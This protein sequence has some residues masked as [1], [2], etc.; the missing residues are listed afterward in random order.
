MQLLQTCTAMIGYCF[1]MSVQVSFILPC[2][3]VERYVADCLDSIYAQ[4]LRE[5][6]YEVI[7]VNDCSTD[8]TRSIIE[9]YARRHSNL[10]LIDHEE[11]SHGCGI[12]RNTGISKAN[13]EYICFVDADDMLPPNVMKDI[14]LTAHRDN[15]DILLFNHIVLSNGIYKENSVKYSSTMVYP[16]G[17]FVENC[18]AGN[19]GRIA[20]AWAKLFKRSFL[21]LYAIRF[22]DLIMAEDSV[23]SWEAVICASRVK[24][25]SETGYI[26]RANDSSMTSGGK[27]MKP[28]M[29]FAESILYPN[30]LKTLEV[31]YRDSIHA[32]IHKGIVNAIKT[33]ISFFFKKYLNCGEDG[34]RA[35]YS[36]IRR[37]PSQV[38]RLNEY[39]N[40]KQRIAFL[41]LFGGYTVF[42]CIVKAMY[43]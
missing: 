23:F 21:S 35:L 28:E 14:C 16:G 19:I 39:L 12:P 8:G 22:T 17:A 18:L 41:S 1:D 2:Y 25:I 5:D 4:G 33:E 36:I 9:N 30:K 20:S 31:K 37:Q 29:I 34:K 38:W 26:F 42:N 7:C 43:L 11:N 27:L 15:L 10:F 32:S 24:S 40:R 3:N 6:E 13:G